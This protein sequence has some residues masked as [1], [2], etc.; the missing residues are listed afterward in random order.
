MSPL[1]VRKESVALDPRSYVA[2]N[3]PQ[4]MAIISAGVIMNLIFAVIFAAVAYR[5]GVKITPCVVAG[6]SASDP[7]WKQAWPS[8]SQIVQLSNSTGGTYC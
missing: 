6:T 4:R 7:A 3:V 5:M 8:G 2:K 1:L